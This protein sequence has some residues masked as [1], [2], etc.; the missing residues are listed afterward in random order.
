MRTLQLAQDAERAAMKQD[1]AQREDRLR[2]SC[3]QQ[4]ERLRQDHEQKFKEQLGNS[5]QAQVRGHHHHRTTRHTHEAAI[6]VSSTSLQS[7]HR[8]ESSKP[9]AQE[10]RA[11][12]RQQERK[13][14]ALET[15]ETRDRLMPEDFRRSASLPPPQLAVDRHALARNRGVADLR[16]ELARRL[17]VVHEG[18]GRNLQEATRVMRLLGQ[19]ETKAFLETEVRCSLHPVVDLQIV[20]KIWKIDHMFLVA[21]SGTGHVRAHHT[22]EFSPFIIFVHLSNFHVDHS[23]GR[24]RED[25]VYR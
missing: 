8:T 11:R 15:A 17:A 7:L 23:R 19:L 3:I 13:D 4:T 12:R 14:P 16:R 25:P 20:V 21:G 24:N 6:D 9:P 22:P 10:N 18:G 1:F 2:A 5:Q